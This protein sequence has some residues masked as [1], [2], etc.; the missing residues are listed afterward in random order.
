M[1]QQNVTSAGDSVTNYVRWLTSFSS[2]THAERPRIVGIGGS[3]YVVLYER[4]SNDGDTFDGTFAL[5]VS[6][7][8]ALLDGPVEIPGDHH[9]SRGDD[10]AALGGRAVYVTGSSDALHLNFVDGDLVAER[11]TLN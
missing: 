9:I 11:L 2:G 4:Y 10:I 7:S 3:E 8:G 1:S 5:L 6:D